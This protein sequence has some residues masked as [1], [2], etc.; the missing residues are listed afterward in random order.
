MRRG[1]RNKASDWSLEAS[2]S[3]ERCVCWALLSSKCVCSRRGGKGYTAVVAAAVSGYLG[4]LPRQSVYEGV[5]NIEHVH[6]GL[7]LT[8][9]CCVHWRTTYYDRLP[10]CP[11]L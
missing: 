9:A 3:L 5:V 7:K 4:L 10:L 2:S 8:A 1:T 11:G 6:E